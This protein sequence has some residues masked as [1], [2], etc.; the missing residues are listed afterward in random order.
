MMTTTDYPRCPFGHI[1]HAIHDGSFTGL[2]FQ[3]V[4]DTCGWKSERV[5]NEELLDNLAGEGR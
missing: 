3:L 2:W 4:C 5:A 1:A